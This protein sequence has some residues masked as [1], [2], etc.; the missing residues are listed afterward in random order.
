MCGNRP[1]RC[2]AWC[3]TTGCPSAL[4]LACARGCAEPR[5]LQFRGAVWILLVPILDR[6]HSTHSLL[7]EAGL[8]GLHGAL[9][10]TGE[11]VLVGARAGTLVGAVF[12]D[13][14]VRSGHIPSPTVVRPA[15]GCVRGDGTMR[16]GH[17]GGMARHSY[18]QQPVLSCRKGRAHGLVVGCFLFLSPRLGP[19]HGG[20][21]YCLDLTPAYPPRRWISQIVVDAL[22][23]DSSATYH[24][25][26]LRR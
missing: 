18:V 21:L 12:R 24:Y 4:G 8:I 3:A 20:T 11:N 13:A 16:A 19:L 14:H 26:R 5:V 23:V 9:Q 2:A 17:D 6:L 22:C 25:Y 1:T 10:Y 15:G 7:L